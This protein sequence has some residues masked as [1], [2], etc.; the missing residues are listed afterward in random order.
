MFD[1]RPTYVVEGEDR[2]GGQAVYAR[3]IMAHL[4]AMAGATACAQWPAPAL[5]CHRNYGQGTA[6]FSRQR[7]VRPA[8]AGQL[9]PRSFLSLMLLKLVAYGITSVCNAPFDSD[10][11]RLQTKPKRCGPRCNA[12]PMLL[13][14]SA[15]LAGHTPKKWCTVASRHVLCGEDGVPWPGVRPGDSSVGES[16]RGAQIGLYPPEVGPGGLLSPL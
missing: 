7:N 11:N 2:C 10:Y 14:M 8:S 4:R 12:L 9:V 16:D 6:D 13:I 15:P 1:T 5:G 3:C